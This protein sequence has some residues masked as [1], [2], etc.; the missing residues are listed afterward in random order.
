MTLMNIANIIE[1]NGKTVRQNNLEKKHNIP[2]GSIVEITYNDSDEE[3][4]TFGLRLF[5][6]DHARDCDGT[7]LYTLSSRKNAMIDYHKSVEETNMAKM[8]GSSQDI[9]LSTLLVWLAKGRL[10]NGY[11]EDCLKVIK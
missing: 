8:S 10:E 5:V 9:Q 7:P 11:S 3:Q 1:A 2:L 6:V 4:N